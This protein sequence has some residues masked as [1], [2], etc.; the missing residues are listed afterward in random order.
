[1]NSARWNEA[2]RSGS[3]K[4]SGVNKS[5]LTMLKPPVAA[6]IP[7]AN[8]AMAKSVCTGL[9]V[10]SLSVCRASATNRIPSVATPEAP[11]IVF[12]YSVFAA[13]RYELICARP[14]HAIDDQHI[15]GTLVRLQ[16][17][18]ELF[19]HGGKNG[20]GIRFRDR[21]CRIARELQS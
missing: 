4:G 6:P 10:Q 17:Q 13:F 21:R 8:A 7:I 18:P 19:L 14:L 12:A 2:S 15:D 16:L 20:C 3:G 1:M 11:F 5:V 9:R